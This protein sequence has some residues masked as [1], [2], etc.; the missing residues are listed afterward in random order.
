MSEIQKSLI[1]E[2]GKAAATLVCERTI[3]KLEEIK[4]TLSGDDSPLEN[5]WEEICCQVQGEESIFWDTYQDFQ[6]PF[7]HNQNLYQV[8]D[9]PQ[10]LPEFHVF[11][12][13]LLQ[14]AR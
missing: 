8:K 6:K 14:K 7:Y 3:T 2:Y 11:Y 10:M 1:R 5:A 13:S 4:D 9:V 12:R